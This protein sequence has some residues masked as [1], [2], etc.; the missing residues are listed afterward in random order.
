MST[1]N[2]IAMGS[3]GKLLPAGAFVAASWQPS[4]L[5]LQCVDGT[6]TLVADWLRDN[7]PCASC[8]IVQTDER[9]WQPWSATGPAESHSATIVDGELVIEWSDGHASTYSRAAFDGFNRAMHRNSY[10]ARLW[11]NGDDLGWFDHDAVLAD[12]SQRQAMFETFQRDGV[13]IISGSPTE[14]GAVIGFAKAINV[15][16]VDSQLGFIFDVKLDPTGYNIAYTAEGL[17]PHNDNAQRT[18]PPSGQVLAMLVNDADGGESFVVDGFSVLEQLRAVDPA[19]VEV[20][21]RVSVGFRQYSKTADG[22]TRAPL[23][24]LDAAGRFTHLRFSNQL[25]QPLPFDHPDLEEWYRA[26]RLL[27]SIVTDPANFVSFRLKAGDMLFV[28]GYRVMHARHEYQPNGPRHLQDVYF[29]VDD[30]SAN[31]ALLTG[32]ATNAMVH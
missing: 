5:E 11:R 12:M 16:L 21:A 7:C 18:H 14:P 10:T 29:D 20:L 28:N 2:E 1:L 23:V 15:A 22:F 19:A 27:G 4:G 31:L 17:P 8:R 9:R 32:Q 30:F 13:V 25:R 3:S 6:A 26:Y 24:A